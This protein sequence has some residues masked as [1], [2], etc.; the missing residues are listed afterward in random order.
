M[1]DYGSI[2]DVP[3]QLRSQLVSLDTIADGA[4]CQ[5]FEIGLQT[6][7]KNIS[8]PNTDPEKARKLTLEFSLSSDI[9][10]RQV[11]CHVHHKT[12]LAP[13]R[14][15]T[16]TLLTSEAGGVVLAAENA[17]VQPSIPGID[18]PTPDTAIQGDDDV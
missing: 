7:L 8:D 17:I 14:E 3:P 13:M 4:A 11:F 2:A 15:I 16:T 5:L 1:T 9:N 6:V 18:A 12:K 10:R